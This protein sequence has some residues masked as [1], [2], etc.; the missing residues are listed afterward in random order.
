M[1]QFLLAVA[2]GAAF[3]APMPSRAAEE[4]K[5][6][7]SKGE[8]AKKAHAAIDELSVKIDALEVKAKKAGAEAKEGLDEKLDA[9]KARRK[10]A[11]KD[12]S[13]LKRTSGKA[14]TKFKAGIDK[15]IAEMKEE[16]SKD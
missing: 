15:G 9:L 16:L 13:K 11:R 2:M 3:V 14:W 4:A 12:L 5:P 10:T 8:Y 7:E 1:K 6:P